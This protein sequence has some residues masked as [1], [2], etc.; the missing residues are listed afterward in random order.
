VTALAARRIDRRA[1]AAQFAEEFPAGHR[2]G[3]TF[4]CI[5]RQ[6]MN[7]AAKSLPLPR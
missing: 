1:E 5:K 7:G 2:D 6:G 3:Y 4:M